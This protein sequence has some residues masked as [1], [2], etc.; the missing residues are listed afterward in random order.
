[1]AAS[2]DWSNLKIDIAV[3]KTFMVAIT[4]ILTLKCLSLS[5]CNESV[6]RERERQRETERETE[7][8]KRY[9]IRQRISGCTKRPFVIYFFFSLISRKFLFLSLSLYKIR[10]FR[11][12]RLVSPHQYKLKSWNLMWVWDSQRIIKSFIRQIQLKSQ[13]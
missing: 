12:A 13:L 9:I 10:F 3:V 5:I 6:W 2:S 4:H 11:N 7:K 8:H 1:M